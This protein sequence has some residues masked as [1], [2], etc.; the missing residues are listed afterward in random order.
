[1]PD[2]NDLLSIVDN[3][4]FNPAIDTG[5]FPNT[6]ASSVWSSSPYANSSDNAWYVYFW[7]GGVYSNVKTYGSH[8]RLVR[9]GQ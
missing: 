3:S 7:D 1:M 8:V 9:G 2:R 6:P 5:Y 4:R